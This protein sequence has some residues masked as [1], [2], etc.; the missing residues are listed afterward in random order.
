L[1][2]YLCR[3][4]IPLD[5]LEAIKK[6]IADRGGVE[7]EL[8]E[9]HERLLTIL[10]GLEAAV[11]ISDLETYEVLFANK[12]LRDIFGDIEGKIC[13]KT[14]QSNQSKP[15]DFCTNDK[16]FTPDGEPA[17]V[18]T[19]EFQNTIFGRWM[20]I[21]DRAIRWVD[22]RL[23]RLEIAVD[24][25]RRKRAEEEV[26]QVRD[27]LDTITNSIHDGLIV[28]E[29]DKSVSYVNESYAHQIGMR[30]SEII[31]RACFSIFH[32]CSDKHILRENGCPLDRVIE[33]RLPQ[34]YTY[35]IIKSGENKWFEVSTA[36]IINQ[37][38]GVTG[39]VE[40]VRDITERKKY[41][42]ALREMSIQ[43]GLTRL[44]NYSYFQKRFD[45]EISRYKRH[46]RSFS[47]MM[48]DL[49]NLKGINDKRGHIEGNRVLFEIADVLRGQVREEIDTVARYGG[50]EYALILPETSLREALKVAQR[51]RKIISA[52]DFK[53]RGGKYKVT[54]SIGLASTSDLAGDGENINEI[55]ELL[56]DHADQAL[57]YCKSR[58][59][60]LVAVFGQLPANQYSR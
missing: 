11:Y 45:A 18:Y 12:Y 8:A 56:I 60:N 36:P 27:Y 15:C 48:M 50:D 6:D 55:K 4:D 57:Y 13:W 24:I 34:V 28:I 40:V 22:G 37:Q 47:L 16:L 49:D 14:L 53:G 5:V 35:H 26:R 2:E 20:E 23:V 1:R 58:G 38:G 43:D 21:R 17:G 46:N 10:D 39:V 44:Y 42:E 29:R 25:T 9:S 30:A 31:G 51:I 7:K 19:W 3:E 59:G 52:K 41:E 32:H 54:V 33:T